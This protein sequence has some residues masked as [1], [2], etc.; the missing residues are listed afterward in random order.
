MKKFPIFFRF[1]YIVNVFSIIFLVFNYT[2][3]KKYDKELSF[4]QK[5]KSFLIG[6]AAGFI[7]S[8]F[9]TGGGLIVIPYLKSKGLSQKS[10]QASAL[11]VLITLSAVSAVTYLNSGYFS[12]RDGIIFI[13]FGFLGALMGGLIVGKISDRLL[14]IVFSL[15]LLYSGIR[16]L[17]R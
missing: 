14:N 3:V 6:T 5:I 1:L 10:A 17:M 11:P 8:L 9:G 16:M 4:M 12:L 13:P 15:F 2:A 7:N